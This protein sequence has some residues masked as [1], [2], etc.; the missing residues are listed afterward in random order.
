MNEIGDQHVQRFHAGAPGTLCH[1]GLNPLHEFTLFADN[2]TRTCE[3]LHH[4][5]VQG[6]DIIECVADF[7]I[8]AYLVDGHACGEVSVLHFVEHF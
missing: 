4:F 7:S 2:S 3:L 6:N 1:R 5:F 8:D